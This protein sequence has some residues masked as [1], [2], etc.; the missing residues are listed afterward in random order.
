MLDYYQVESRKTAIYPKGYAVVYPALG[1]CGE[2]AEVW[3]KLLPNKDGKKQQ[4]KAADVQ[5]ELGDVLWYITQT[6]ADADILL[7]DLAEDLTGG[8]APTKFADLSF[9]L[10]DKKDKRSPY[11]KLSEL[12]GAVAEVVK[13][14]LRDDLGDIGPRRAK[15]RAALGATLRAWLEIHELH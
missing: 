5:P 6:A 1:L 3:G 14:S 7:L 15:L 4:I 12:S 9:Q 8:L 11:V 10:L 2:A 13:K